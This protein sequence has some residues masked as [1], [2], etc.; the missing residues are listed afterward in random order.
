MPKFNRF[1]KQKTIHLLLVILFPLMGIAQLPDLRLENLTNL[2]RTGD[3]GAVVEFNFDLINSGTAIAA[4]DYTITM[5]LSDDYFFGDADDI[6]VGEIITG[7]TAVGTIPN[8]L[9]AITIPNNIN[10]GNY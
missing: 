3:I 10:S 1:T 2:S 4:G 6:K 5:Y 8:V 7:N 9:G